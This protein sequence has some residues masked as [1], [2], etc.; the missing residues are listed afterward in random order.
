MEVESTGVST[1]KEKGKAGGEEE[2]LRAGS[3]SMHA[4]RAGEEPWQMVGRGGRPLGSTVNSVMVSGK[5][6]TFGVKNSH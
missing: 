5:R 3:S 6:T 4:L 2:T 1:G